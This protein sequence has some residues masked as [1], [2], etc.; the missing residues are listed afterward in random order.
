MTPT[1]IDDFDHWLLESLADHRNGGFTWLSRHLLTLG[2]TAP[3]VITCLLIAMVIVVVLRL[4]R[5]TTA[6]LVAFLLAGEATHV[7]KELFERPRPPAS[8]AITPAF[9]YSMPSSVAATV[10]AASLAAFLAVVW[11]SRRRRTI[12][13]W[14]FVGVQ[15][16][17]GFAMVYL[18]AH[19]ASDV[20][21]GWALGAVVGG[22]VGLAVRPT[23][24]VSAPSA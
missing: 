17:I 9:G 23:S 24:K 1:S 6:A 12:A 21:A 16:V 22:V 19:W 18:G 20:V 7:L 11:P 3:G 5:P 8:L 2:H 15:A 14:T 13:A 4:W 10:G